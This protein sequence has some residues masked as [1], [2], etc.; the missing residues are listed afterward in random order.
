[1]ALGALVAA[2]RQG[3]QIPQ[4]LSIVGFDDEPHAAEVFPSLTT[5]NHNLKRMGQLAAEKLTALCKNQPEA[6]AA[7][8]TKLELNLIT[9]ESTANAP[10]ES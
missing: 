6:A 4:Q 3:I 9:R 7:I 8:D 5:V 1:M 2:T 10:L